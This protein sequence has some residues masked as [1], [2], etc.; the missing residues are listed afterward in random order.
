MG[1]VEHYKKM[2]LQINISVNTD[3][4]ALNKIL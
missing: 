4:K 2:K 3:A 1:E